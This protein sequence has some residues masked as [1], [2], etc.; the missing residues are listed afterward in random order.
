MQNVNL[1]PSLSPEKNQ[2]FQHREEVRK[3][4]RIVEGLINQSG[5][6]PKGHA[7]LCIP[8]EMKKGLIVLPDNVGDRAKML[9]DRVIV[10]EIGPD[11]WTGKTARAVV[12]ERVMIS[13]FAGTVVKGPL[14]DKIYRIINDQDIYIGIEEKE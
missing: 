14:D 4:S 10:L 2:E 1:S 11:A 13:K 9:E 8:Y 12:G 3:T 6:T 5:I 7:I